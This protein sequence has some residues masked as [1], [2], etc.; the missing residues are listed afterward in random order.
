MDVASI[1]RTMDLVEQESITVCGCILLDVF[2]RLCIAEQCNDIHLALASKAAVLGAKNDLF[3]A[4][5]VLTETSSMCDESS[6]CCENW[7]IE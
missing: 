4:G 7:S 1:K 3:P 6:G 2:A 5:D